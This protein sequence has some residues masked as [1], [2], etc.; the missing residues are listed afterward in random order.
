[1]ADIKMIPDAGSCVSIAYLWIED[2]QKVLYT[3]NVGDSEIYLFKKDSFTKL[4]VD[5]H[6]DNEEE[7]KWI[8]DGGAEIYSMGDECMRV[9]GILAV[10]WSLGDYELKSSGVITSPYI[11]W[12]VL[13]DDHLYL[14]VAS[15]GIWDG[16][17]PEK[18]SHILED[19]PDSTEI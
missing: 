9:E 3:A 16:V 1:M 2:G 19:F 15:D 10:T 6:T 18:A 11:T 17:T 8:E 5:H 7:C 14:I 13:T 12:T 4:T